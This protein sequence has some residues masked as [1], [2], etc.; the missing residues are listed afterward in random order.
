MAAKGSRQLL[1][2][3]T[4]SGDGCGSEIFLMEYVAS[5]GY[6]P[7]AADYAH[8]KPSITGNKSPFC[9]LR[10]GNVDKRWRLVT[11]VRRFAEDI[12]G[13]RDFLLADVGASPDVLLRKGSWGSD[14]GKT[15]R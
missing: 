6:I 14:I 8:T 9:R 13:K 4:H 5:H 7:V 10:G 15:G 3:S 1:S 2:V 11:L 12:S